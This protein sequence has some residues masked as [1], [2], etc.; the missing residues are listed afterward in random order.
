MID[1]KR[2]DE[3]HGRVL[4]TG[5]V[6]GDQHQVRV[7]RVLYV[8]RPYAELA[9]EKLLVHD[10]QMDLVLA[11]CGLEIATLAGH[12]TV[13]V[14]V[15]GFGRVISPRLVW[16]ALQRRVI[17]VHELLDERNVIVPVGRRQRDHVLSCRV[18]G[19]NIFRVRSN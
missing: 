5:E 8:D 16:R 19:H 13:H 3:H 10:V 7:E 18:V 12:V 17:V 1:Q 6:A 14:H 11:D 4:V 2:L 9:L 15:L